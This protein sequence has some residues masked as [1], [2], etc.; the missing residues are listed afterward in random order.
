MTAV[1]HPVYAIIAAAGSGSR[2]GRETNKQFLELGSCP[3]IV[4]TFRT[5][6]D[7]SQVTGI[8][9]MATADQIEAMRSC[10]SQVNTSKLITIAAGGATRQESV[11][12]GLRAL[13]RTTSPQAN[14]PILVHDGARCFVTIPIIERV[15]EGILKYKAC[16]AAVQVKDTIKEAMTPGTALPSEVALQDADGISG[17]QV[18]RTLERNRLWS[19]QTP[20]GALFALIDEAYELAA[21]Q[22]WQASDDLSLLELAGHTVFLVNGDYKNI[23]ITTPDDRLF[24]EWLAQTHV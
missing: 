24:G 16:G 3:V 2:M 5:F 11:L 10:L 4:R 21:R 7:C 18:I 1:T 8:I 15:I 22:N 9:V 14:S 12:L 20:Q 13:S 19:M 17:L 6:A 23:K